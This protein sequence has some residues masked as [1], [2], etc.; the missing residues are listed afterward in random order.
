WEAAIEEQRNLAERVRSLEGDLRKAMLLEDASLP[1]DTVA[2]G[3]TVKF[4]NTA[5]KEVST[6]TIL[7]PWDMLDRDDVISYRAPLAQGLLGR[8]AGETT[9]FALP[10]GEIEVEVLGIETAD[11]D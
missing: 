8:H 6:L 1:E 7:G 3:T 9:R 10:S 11:I 5:S 4:R 2:P